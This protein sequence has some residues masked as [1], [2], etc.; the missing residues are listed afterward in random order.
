VTSNPTV[1]RESAYRPLAAESVPHELVKAVS[2]QRAKHADVG[3]PAEQPCRVRLP[4]PRSRTP[5]NGEH[6]G[7]GVHA[8]NDTHVASQR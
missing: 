6:V 7:F 8:D 2:N 4:V 1:A 5:R 3:V